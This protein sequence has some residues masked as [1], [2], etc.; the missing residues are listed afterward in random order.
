MRTRAWR[1]SPREQLSSADGRLSTVDDGCPNRARLAGDSGAAPCGRAD[2]GQATSLT[3]GRHVH[4][5]WPEPSPDAPRRC[6][7]H[8]ATPRAALRE[9]R[10]SLA[11]ARR[12]ERRLEREARLGGLAPV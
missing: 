7:N 8:L 4:T 10:E 3:C 11:E 9:R 1:T 2:L 6:I 12:R 5:A